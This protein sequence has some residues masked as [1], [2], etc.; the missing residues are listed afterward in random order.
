MLMDL[1]LNKLLQFL[2]LF[3]CFKELVGEVFD[4]YPYRCTYVMD[5]KECLL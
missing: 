4:F 3:L 1:H 2:N 5:V